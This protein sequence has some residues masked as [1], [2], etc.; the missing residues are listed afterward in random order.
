M[1]FC[2]LLYQRLEVSALSNYY[3]QRQLAATADNY[4]C[5]QQAKATTDFL[6]WFQ[7]SGISTNLNTQHG[8]KI[9][10]EKREDYSAAQAPSISREE[11]VEVVASSSRNNDVSEIR[12]Q[13]PFMILDEALKSFPKFNA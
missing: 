5:Q 13:L 4:R 7:V 11:P 8:E 3:Y 9:V 2:D 12:K 1:I 10:S 6:Y